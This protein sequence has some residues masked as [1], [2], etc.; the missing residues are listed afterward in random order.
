MKNQNILT[1]FPTTVLATGKRVYQAKL[2]ALKDAL[3]RESLSGYSALFEKVL[4]MSKLQEWDMTQRKRFYCETLVFWAWTS[5][6][7]EGN[8]S[9]TKAVSMV[10]SW[11]RT[12]KLAI[13]G[14]NTSPYT[15]AR[16]KLSM[17]FLTNIDQAVKSHLSRNTAKRDLWKGHRLLAI[18]GT[19]VTL[20]DTAKNQEAYPQPSGQKEGC[21]FPVMGIVGMVDLSHGGIIEVKTCGYQKHDARV[22]PE[23]LESIDEGDIVSGDRA[24]CSFEFIARIKQERN[25]H[26]LMRLHQARHRAL[27]WRRGKQLSN[28]ERL[29]TWQR[30]KKPSKGSNLTQEEWDK[31]PEEI[32]LRYIKMS[33]ENRAGDKETLVVV[34]DLLDPV[35][36]PAIEVADLYS[37]RWEIEVK[38]RD[39]KTH[40]K[41]EHFAVKCPE[42]AHRTLAMMIITY[43]LIRTVMQEAAEEADVKVSHMSVTGIRCVLTSSHESFRGLKG[44]PICY[45]K[46]WDALIENCSQH[47][48][49]IRPFRQEPR[50]RKRRPKNYQL[51]TKHRRVFKE[52]PH[53]SRY[54]KAA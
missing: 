40:M 52:I 47:A 45:Q 18:D 6:I 17:S 51:L 30:A 21:G 1:N 46:H 10:Q 43:N 15:R 24:F 28:I 53:R 44:K 31:L 16:K 35:E 12:L 13:P 9:C 32:T 29:V 19:T 34:T 11:Y 5:Q 27:D 14:S 26:V 2:N 42:V 41:M 48:L 25:G 54:R 38:F 37:E 20:D 50:A 33:Y 22:A 36:Y 3:K 8:A 49:N 7:M 39:I 23:L 4:P